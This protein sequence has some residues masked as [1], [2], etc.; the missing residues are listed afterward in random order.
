[1]WGCKPKPPIFPVPTLEAV[2]KQMFYDG[3]TGDIS[4]LH[5]KA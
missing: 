3:S 5:A 2:A 1:M 4:S